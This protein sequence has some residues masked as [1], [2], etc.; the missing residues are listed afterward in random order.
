M[1][2]IPISLSVAFTVAMTIA[3]VVFSGMDIAVGISWNTGAWSLKSVTQTL[4]FAVATCPPPSS[5]LAIKEYLLSV[6]L[7]RVWA[8]M[9]EPFGARVKC[10]SRS[11]PVKVSVPNLP[12][13][14]SLTIITSITV[15]TGVSSRT[16]K[17]RSWVGENMG[18]LSF[19]SR[20]FTRTIAEELIEGMPL[21][22]AI[23]LNS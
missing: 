15:S 7:S 23:T 3:L 18:R 20:I 9:R 16:S 8:S 11:R 14:S 19:S 13:S 6:S 21:S 22:L 5:A 2:F 12:E 17:L 10:E 1:L 4:T